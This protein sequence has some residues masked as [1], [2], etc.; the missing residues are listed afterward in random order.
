MT[1][2]LT[3]YRPGAMADRARATH[4]HRGDRPDQPLAERD[5]MVSLTRDLVSR[6]PSLVQ[7]ASRSFDASPL[8]RWGLA[9]G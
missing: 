2:V 8:R 1:R 4:S 9:R 7:E 5:L 3:G 6:V